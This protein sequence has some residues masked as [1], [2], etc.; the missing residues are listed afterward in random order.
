VDDD[1]LLEPGSLSVCGECSCHE[2]YDTEEIAAWLHPVGVASWLP[3]GEFTAD[4][5]W[6]PGHFDPDWGREKLTALI[7]QAGG[8]VHTEA[9]LA[10]IRAD[11]GVHLDDGLHRWSIA[12]DQG[13]P[14][15]PVEMRRPGA[16]KPPWAYAF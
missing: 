15:I 6:E 3:A 5:L 12:R 1:T 7:R 9:I 10:T 13:I 2:W 14:R 11:G 8:I 4:K 16:E